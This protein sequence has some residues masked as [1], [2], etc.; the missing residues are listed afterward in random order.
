MLEAE[1]EALWLALI[2]ADWLAL[3]E[4]EAEFWLL[5]AEAEALM[6]ALTDAE[7]L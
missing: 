6:L 3:A 4:I 5:D 1:A 7:V 2:D